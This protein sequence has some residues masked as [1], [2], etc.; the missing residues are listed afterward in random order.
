ML[1][2]A[3]LVVRTESD[4]PEPCLQSI[5]DLVDQ[6]VIVDTRSAGGAAPAAAGRAVRVL[7]F[8]AGDVLAAL[9]AGLAEAQGD[10]VLAIEATERVVTADRPRLAALLSDENVLAC[11][12]RFKPRLGF[13]R[14]WEPRIFRRDPG[15]HFR[16]VADEPLRLHLGSIVT[17]GVRVI[18]QSDMEIDRV[19]EEDGRHGQDRFYTVA[20]LEARIAED[21]G[22]VAAW[23]LLGRALTAR[24]DQ[25]GA[26][27]AWRRAVRIVR[28]KASRDPLDSLPYVE[29]LQHEPREG[30]AHLD[31]ALRLF[32]ENY[33]FAWSH[34]SRLLEAGRYRQ[35][36]PRL[37]RLTTVE[38][39]TYCDAGVAYDERIFGEFAH[40]ALG[41]C[42]F[43]LGRYRESA[44][45]YG[46]AEAAAPHDQSYR[47]KR[48][49][50][51]VQARAARGSTGATPV[52][53]RPAQP[54]RPR[55]PEAPWDPVREIAARPPLTSV[56]WRLRSGRKTGRRAMVVAHRIP[57]PDRTSESVRLMFLL[58]GIAG[59]GWDITLV[60]AAERSK[61]AWVLADVEQELPRYERPLA[62]LGVKIVYGLKNA[63]RHLHREG[64]TYSLAIL[65]SCHVMYRYA[66]FVRA[67]MPGA[68]LI[69]D[70]VDLYW[71]R[72]A[73][74]ATVK[75]N[76]RALQH[77]AERYR[78]MDGVSFEIADGIVAITEEERD[79]ILDACPTAEVAVL[80]NIHQPSSV[81]PGQRGRAGLVFIGHYLHT[82]NHDAVQYFCREILPLIHARLPGVD[83]H[84]LGSSMPDSIT[85]LKSERVHPVGYVSDPG[86]YFNAARVFVAPLRYG[87]GMKGK[88][89]LSLSLGLPVVTTPIGAEGMG[90]R[91]GEEVLIAEDAPAFADAVWRLHTDDALW[92]RLS[93]AGLLYIRQRVSPEAVAPTVRR[94]LA[95]A[96]SGVMLG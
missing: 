54:N 83:F 69:Y 21:P 19:R 95:D 33:F 50:A 67:Y 71:L 66:P 7:D 43:R 37:E 10:F 68:R 8:A 1:L 9:N 87:A 60:S 88:I 5:A 13:T 90:L 14:Y 84:I 85:A 73:R 38:P 93:R 25:R 29:L 18:V 81:P 41:L 39:N 6:I 27:K 30:T 48:Q 86:P 70:V 3:V 22:D 78:R 45:H 24:G 53:R 4:A 11:R 28:G 36:L 77:K 2:S 92:D 44:Q 17:G 34:V 75:A 76:D 63:I 15:F 20:P 42:H 72:V 49:L 57:T 91:D 56:P 61:Y 79:R 55:S 59:E 32:P 96:E 65:S 89:G 16:A 12:V 47:V 80:P 26:L 23:A 52:A 58:K 64:G 74:E 46:K 35:A 82:P 40:D 94:L 31:E 51:E 62:G